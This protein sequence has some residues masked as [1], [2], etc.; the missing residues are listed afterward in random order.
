MADDADFA[1]E[2]MD[3]ELE[4]AMAARVMFSGVSLAECE[5]CGADIPEI[6]RRVLPGVR[7]CVACAE[8][9]EKGWRRG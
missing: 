8:V 1:G 3:V 6:R 2:R 4:R 9:A 7:V 5:E